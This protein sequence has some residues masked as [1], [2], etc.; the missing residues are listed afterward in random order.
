MDIEKARRKI[1]DEIRKNLDVAVVGLSG[2]ADS[3]TVALL[4]ADS[5]GKEN[6]YSYSLPFSEYDLRTFNKKSENYALHIGI[7]HQII[8]IGKAAMALDEAVRNGLNFIEGKSLGNEKLSTLNSGNCRARIRTSAL[9]GI[10]HH[11]N[12][13]LKKRVRVMG[14]GN[15]SE[16]FIGYDTK[17]GDALADI[18]PIG[19]LFKSEVYA[20]L[21]YYRDKGV[22][23][24]DMINRNPSAGLWEGQTDESEIGYSYNEMEG[25]VR[26]ILANYDSIGSEV[27]A[28]DDITRFVWF[29][30]LANKHKH[31]APPVIRIRD[32]KGNICL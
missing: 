27:E 17:G 16:D 24:E 21:E 3:L 31:E 10:A 28:L 5:L 30:H 23:T 12:E 18:F 25:A 22:I 15:L 7:R 14:T 32:K 2:G 11:L 26:Y 20:M 6:V 9:Y 13:T 19:H 29:R 4:C 8:E 1:I